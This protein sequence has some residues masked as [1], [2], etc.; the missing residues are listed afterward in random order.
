MEA[1]TPRAGHRRCRPECR[2]ISGRTRRPAK[3]HRW[4]RPVAITSLCRRSLPHSILPGHHYHASARERCTRRLLPVNAHVAASLSRVIGLGE[5]ITTSLEEYEVLAL[6]L[7]HDA[8]LLGRMRVRLAENRRGFRSSTPSAP[9][10]ISNGLFAAIPNPERGPV[11]HSFS[12]PSA[13]D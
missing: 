7:A 3:R 8:G 1:E 13:S 11:A 5:L 6:R 12:I 2:S 9:P 10:A 4:C